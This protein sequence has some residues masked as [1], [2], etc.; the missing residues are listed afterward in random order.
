V[1]A[2][3]LETINS[4]ILEYRDVLQTISQTRDVEDRRRLWNQASGLGSEL[5]RLLPPATDPLSAQ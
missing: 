1:T 2:N 5:D 3:D 4:L